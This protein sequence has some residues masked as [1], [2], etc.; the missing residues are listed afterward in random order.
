MLDTD[1]PLDIAQELS[2]IPSEYQDIFRQALAQELAE[3]EQNRTDMDILTYLRSRREDFRQGS[4]IRPDGRPGIV[5]LDP[6]ALYEQALTELVQ[7]SLGEEDDHAERRQ[8][9]WKLLLLGGILLLL[10]FFAFRS[11]AQ[12]EAKIAD[13]TGTPGA[14]VGEAVNTPTSPLPDI[15][16]AETSL[17]TIGNLGGAL[18]IGRPS[19]L[20]IYYRSSEETIALAIDPSKP[21]PK[22]EMRYSEAT[23]RSDNPVAVWLFGTVLNYA[24]GIPDG[25]VRNLEAGDILTLSSDTGASLRFIVAE[26]GQGASY[27]TGRLL[28]QNRLGLTLFALPAI[29]EEAVTYAFAHYDVSSEAGQGQSIHSVGDN[30]VFSDGAEQQV[31]A[32]HY[33]HALDGNFRIVVSGLGPLPEH[34]TTY[35][36]SLTTPNEQTTAVP[37]AWTENRRWQASF[38]LPNS[39]A[40]QTLLAEVRSMPSGGLAVVN[41]GEIPHLQAQLEVASLEAWWDPTPAEA[42]LTVTLHNPGEAAVYLGSNFIQ[43]SNRTA[44]ATEGGDAHVRIGQQTPPL[45]LLIHPGETVGITISFLPQ[46]ASIQLQIGTEL[47]EVMGFPSH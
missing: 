20:E 31:T 30:F 36:L 18:T 21:T 27:D 34:N 13:P 43:L 17:Q 28:S 8:T 33:E 37:L 15:S 16:G 40:G 38:S 10:L 32:V 6:E 1:L 47:W 4:F 41:L 7:S 9:M 23:M 26:T 14:V 3:A 12:R 11:R 35:L 42:M 44:P 39:V 22:G 24:L 2:E 45:P 19:A 29:G 46:T 5:S 25:L